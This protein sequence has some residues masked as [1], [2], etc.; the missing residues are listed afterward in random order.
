MPFIPADLDLPPKAITLARD[1]R[2]GRLL[3][4]FAGANADLQTRQGV[5]WHCKTGGSAR[6]ITEA[7]CKGILGISSAMLG[8]PRQ[9]NGASIS[10]AGPDK[11][12]VHHI[13]DNVE[14]D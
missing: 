9:A 2:H 11:D 8:A 14:A 13:M 3:I 12:L 5:L 10:S 6:E 7:T 4:R 1:E